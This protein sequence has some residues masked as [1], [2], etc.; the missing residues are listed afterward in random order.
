MTTINTRSGAWMVIYCKPRR[1]FLFG[2][3][4]PQMR[5]P[6]LWNLFGGHLDPDEDPRSGVLREVREEAGLDLADRRIIRYTP[7]GY[8]TLGYV[9]GLRDMHYFL[10]VTIEEFA[11]TLDYE[12]SAYGWYK[13]ESLPH[14]VNRPTA[15]A[16]NIGLFVKTLSMAD[17]GLLSTGAP[18]SPAIVPI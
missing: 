6:D 13:A 10:M 7:E 16:L 14:R 3:R 11:P 2:K 4:G 1:T 18:H 15:I 12:H 17:D 9:S 5:K 8:G